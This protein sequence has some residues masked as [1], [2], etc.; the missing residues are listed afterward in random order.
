MDQDLAP[1]LDNSIH[2]VN[3][4]DGDTR[5]S[6]GLH[7]GNGCN[8]A[9]DKMDKTSYRRL[10]KVSTNCNSSTKIMP[11]KANQE[12]CLNLV[13]DDEF[14]CQ[15]LETIQSMKYADDKINT[16]TDRF[17][18]A[19]LERDDLRV[20]LQQVRESYQFAIADYEKRLKNLTTESQ[21]SVTELQGTIAELSRKLTRQNEVLKTTDRNYSDVDDVDTND[22]NGI[23]SEFY[24]DESSIINS[25]SRENGTYLSNLSRVTNT[26][27]NASS[28]NK[29]K[30][31]DSMKSKEGYSHGKAHQDSSYYYGQHIRNNIESPNLNYEIMERTELIDAM[32]NLRQ[33]YTDLAKEKEDLERKI[34]YSKMIASDLSQ[35]DMSI[36]TG[37]NSMMRTATSPDWGNVTQDSSSVIA[38]S[39]KKETNTFTT[40]ENA[41]KDNGRNIF[42]RVD[43]L[44]NSGHVSNEMLR[45]SLESPS[46]QLN[47]IHSNDANYCAASNINKRLSAGFSDY[48]QFTGGDN[49]VNVENA[50]SK[51]ND[52]QERKML[53]DSPMHGFI[54]E[55]VL[56]R[57]QPSELDSSYLSA[58]SNTKSNNLDND[59]ESIEEYFSQLHYKELLLIIHRCTNYEELF[60]GL[61]DYVDNVVKAKMQQAVSDHTSLT[62][63]IDELTA[64][65]NALLLAIEECKEIASA[66]TVLNGKYESNCAILRSALEYTDRSL[67][68]YEL[69]ASLFEC[70]LRIMLSQCRSLGIKS[71]ML[72]SSDRIR[73]YY[74][75]D[76]SS[77][78]LQHWV[79]RRRNIEDA[80]IVLLKDFNAVSDSKTTSV[81]Q[82][83]NENSAVFNNTLSMDDQ[84]RLKSYARK[85]IDKRTTLRVVPPNVEQISMEGI[86]S[87]LSNKLKQHD[88]LDIDTAVHLLDHVT[89]KEDIINL[90]YKTNILEKE[91]K[92]LQLTLEIYREKDY[93]HNLKLEQLLTSSSDTSYR[94][95]D[96]SLDSGVIVI[97]ESN[98]SFQIANPT[99]RE[100]QHRRRTTRSPE[101]ELSQANVITLNEFKKSLK[102]IKLLTE[103]KY[104]YNDE[105]IEDLKRSNHELINAYDRAKQRLKLKIK[106][107]EDQLALIY[108]KSPSQV[109]ISKT[110]TNTLEKLFSIT[111]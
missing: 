19:I 102:Q 82:L 95:N 59:N 31:A 86:L 18:R 53:Q 111:K 10:N 33:S 106:L 105:L 92:I 36:T 24:D 47:E 58:S 78:Y 89:R 42:Q 67:E 39:R 62:T 29:F 4:A 74:N 14:D 64:D 108:N 84:K 68:I 100:K 17:R 15:L 79:D 50:T 88:L 87:T 90:K 55:M 71:S 11:L 110:K 109:D 63:K 72:T 45:N 28:S 44:N 1:K 80:A 6:K 25:F 32:K 61:M 77:D 60:H 52:R 37:E 40:Q 85:L 30:K 41:C 107:L 83:S 69:L 34:H 49:H 91:K 48:L 94:S 12:E 93:V 38:A 20:E 35:N 75:L 73:S 101:D 56:K 43:S 65:N 96:R 8:D 66:L 7:L 51:Q 23:N 70:D 26:G 22:L 13:V 27:T 57:F 103:T 97:D 81:S 54:N 16:L 76:K 2:H 104:Q 21:H 5:C 9:S 98:N 99:T 46:F 3:I